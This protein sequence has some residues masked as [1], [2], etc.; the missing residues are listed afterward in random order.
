MNQIFVVELRKCAFNGRTCQVLILR[1]LTCRKNPQVV[2]KYSKVGQKVITFT[3][4][5]LT[6]LPKHVGPQQVKFLMSG[7]LSYMCKTNS[8]QFELYSA[9]TIHSS[10]GLQSPEPE[11]P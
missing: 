9:I 5:Q 1:S 11:P 6:H 8:I 4:I 7:L 3:F 10:Q 2:W